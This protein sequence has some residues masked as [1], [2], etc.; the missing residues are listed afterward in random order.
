[1]YDCGLKVAELLDQYGIKSGLVDVTTIK[2]MDLRPLEDITADTQ[3]IVTIED[4]SVKGGFGMQLGAAVTGTGIK[5]LNFAWP[6][7]FIPQGSF[8]QLAD[9]FGLTAEKIAERICEII[10]G[11]A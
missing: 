6:D 10:E 7:E 9:R 5:V 4:N 8:D 2:P 11:K 3:Y 1:M